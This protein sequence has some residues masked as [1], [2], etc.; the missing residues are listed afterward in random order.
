MA[1][2]L[3]ANTPSTTVSSG[4]TD[5]PASG[6]PETW[7]VTSSAEF[8]AAATGVSQFHVGDPAATSEMIAVTNVS[9]STWTVTR[10]AEST[11][12]VAHSAGFTVQQVVTAGALGSFAQAGLGDLGG[13]GDDPQ[14]VSTHL[15]S[16][17][18]TTQG[19]TGQDAASSSALLTALGALQSADNLSDVASE[20]TA[21]ANLGGLPLA[22][23]TMSGV[24]AMGS[25]KITGLTNGS[26][27]QDAAAFGQIPASLPPSGTAGGVLSGTYPN[28]GF[29]TTPLP[30][31]GGTMTGALVPATVALS[32]GT[33]IAVNAALGNVFA[34]TLTASTGTLANPTNPADGQA[35]RVRVI[36][37][38]GG[39]FT[40]AFGT[41][42]DFGAAGAPTLS[43]P[44]A[45]VDILG[46]EY[47]ASLSKWCFLGSG[48]G[49]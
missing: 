5:A 16:P 29:A 13:S 21:L 25:H 23:G 42:Y 18:P 1:A 40:A 34:V 14:V 12:P 9:G 3:F 24:I 26:G 46:F 38:S 28:P 8:P 43:T 47:V 22:G 39:S 41:A 31:S 30:Q 20:T 48:L 44:A 2:E 11:T 33:S 32:F 7:T 36:Q 37:G 17:L 27:A 19:G 35:I 6:T 15:A 49:F 4:G 45:K 10:G